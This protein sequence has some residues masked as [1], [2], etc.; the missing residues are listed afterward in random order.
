MVNFDVCD[1]WSIIAYTL[2]VNEIEVHHNIQVY[3]KNQ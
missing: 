2:D 3:D 1:C